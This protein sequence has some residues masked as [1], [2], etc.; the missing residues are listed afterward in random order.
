MA[1]TIP[2]TPVP[3]S[4]RFWLG[5]ALPHVMAIVLL[6]IFILIGGKGLEWS[7]FVAFLLALVAMPIA[8]LVACWVLFVRWRGTVSLATA[9]LFVPFGMVLLVAWNMMAA[10]HGSSGGGKAVEPL[11]RVLALAGHYPWTFAVLWLAALV[12]LVLAARYRD[13]P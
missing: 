6:L 12:A 3:V 10:G 13:A 11:F 4:T 7:P 5:V 1:T 2:G 8:I 9:G